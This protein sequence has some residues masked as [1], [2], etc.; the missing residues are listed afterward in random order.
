MHSKLLLLVWFM[1][2][3]VHVTL[4]SVDY[5]PKDGGL[6]VF[7]KMY[8]DD[9]LLDAQQNDDAFLK[10]E[11]KSKE[12]IENYINQKLIIKSNNKPLKG[13]IESFELINNLEVFEN[14]IKVY[15]EYKISKKPQELL[16]RNLIM[17]ELYNDQSNL[18]I[19]K[20]DNFEEGFKFSSEITEQVFKIGN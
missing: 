19:I 6:K 4:T 8:S 15:M 1:F 20:I 11:K 12:I 7:I 16:V 13:K 9:F 14:E 10:D 3:P 2:H 18:I 17:T 5:A